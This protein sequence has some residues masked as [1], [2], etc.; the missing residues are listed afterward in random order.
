[1][2]RVEVVY[3]SGDE[4]ISVQWHDFKLIGD[5]RLV[6]DP[7]DQTCGLIPDRLDGEIFGGGRI[8]GVICFEIPVRTNVA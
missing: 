1:M 3:P 2:I 5:N 8:E 7:F 4:S 6:Y